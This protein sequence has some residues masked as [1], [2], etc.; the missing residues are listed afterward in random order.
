MNK[1]LPISLFVGFILG[2][3]AQAII[4]DAEPPKPAATAKL[5]KPQKSAIEIENE[6][7]KKELVAM[8]RQQKEANEEPVQVIEPPSKPMLSIGSAGPGGGIIFYLDSSGEHGLEAQPADYTRQPGD[9]V[10]GDNAYYTWPHAMTAGSSYGSGWRLPTKEELNQL[11]LQKSV[12]GGF[13]DDYYWSST[14]SGS[15]LAWSQ[16]FL[17]GYLFDG[18]KGYSDRVRAVRA[19]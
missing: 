19:F 14:E 3:P 16:G 2:L 10:Y 4:L 7:M 11:Y 6:R 8:K 12:V 13:A 9:Y 15:G 18:Y 17:N 1:F 5:K